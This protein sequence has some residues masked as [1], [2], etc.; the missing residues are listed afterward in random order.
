M[1]TSKLITI[2]QF[3]KIK[4][5]G[6]S[7]SGNPLLL[8]GLKLYLFSS[9]EKRKDLFCSSSKRFI[10]ESASFLKSLI[11]VPESMFNSKLSIIHSEFTWGIKKKI[12]IQKVASC[13]RK[14]SYSRDINLFTSKLNFSFLLV[15]PPNS[16]IAILFEIFDR[17]FGESWLDNGLETVEVN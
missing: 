6:R 3:K 17:L 15:I 10:S 2:S 4:L 1:F 8:L 5:Q 7:K 13:N 16:L 9:V 14:L 12:L 11:F